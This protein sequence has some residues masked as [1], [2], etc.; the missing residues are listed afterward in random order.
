[1]IKNRLQAL[2]QN[3]EPRLSSA[4]CLAEV[5]A[6]MIEARSIQHFSLERGLRIYQPVWNLTATAHRTFRA[7]MFCAIEKK[8]SCLL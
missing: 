2:N 1:M 3:F 8:N 6:S 4:K 7:Q 5:I